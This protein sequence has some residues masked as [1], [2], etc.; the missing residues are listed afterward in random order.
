MLLVEAANTGE[1][2]REKQSRT[3][4]AA[5][6]GFSFCSRDITDSGATEDYSHKSRHMHLQPGKLP[7][8]AATQR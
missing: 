8:A 7:S 4:H 3:H 6:C 2:K 1:V 5:H